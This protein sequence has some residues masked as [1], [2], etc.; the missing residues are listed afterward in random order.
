MNINANKRVSSKMGGLVQEM[1][2]HAFLFSV[3]EKATQ[4]EMDPNAERDCA[5]R[6]LVP[7]LSS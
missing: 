4:G 5:R 2:Y 6:P 7:L 1:H 3:D